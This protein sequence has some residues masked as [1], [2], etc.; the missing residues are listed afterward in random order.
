MERIP[1]WS[2]LFLLDRPPL[3]TTLHELEP[4]NSY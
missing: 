1:K 2:T 3:E 4:Q